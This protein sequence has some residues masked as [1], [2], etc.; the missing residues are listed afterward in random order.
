MHHSEKFIKGYPEELRLKDGHCD[1]VLGYLVLF[2]VEH[3]C[4][5]EFFYLHTEYQTEF[6]LYHHV[7]TRRAEEYVAAMGF[8]ETINHSYGHVSTS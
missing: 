4:E 2:V 7:V 5:E 1:L 3:D 8:K 6:P